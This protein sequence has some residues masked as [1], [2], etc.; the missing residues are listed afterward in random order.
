MQSGYVIEAYSPSL[1]ETHRWFNLHDL[2]PV[3]D[4]LLAKQY[5]D[6]FA[7]QFNRDQKNR[8]TDW[9]GKVSWQDLGIETITGYIAPR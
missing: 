3:Q 6:S 5:A 1:N 2:A 4:E 7:G 9:V 8:A